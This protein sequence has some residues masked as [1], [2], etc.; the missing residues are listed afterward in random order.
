MTSS[1]KTSSTTQ[2]RLLAMKIGRKD[3]PGS[4]DEPTNAPCL[5]E[6]KLQTAPKAPCLHELKMRTAQKK[7]YLNYV[8]T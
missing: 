5:H 3:S 1:Q 8:M 6:L 4:L 2:S 7:K